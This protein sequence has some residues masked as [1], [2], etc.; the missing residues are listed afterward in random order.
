MPDSP[1]L[2]PEALKA[3]QNLAASAGIAP[4]D[5]KPSQPIPASAAAFDQPPEP[6]ADRLAPEELQVLREMIV[7]HHRQKTNE[8]VLP[9]KP[10][11]KADL[12][13]FGDS[14]LAR[15][16]YSEQMILIPKK[17]E[18]VLRCKT[19]REIDAIERQI[20]KD[21]KAN[22]ILNERVY[23]MTL[24]NYRLM[25]QWVALNGV[26]LESPVALL[27]SPDFD[28]RK[29]ME[30]HMIN[31]LPEP[32]MFM[33]NGALGQF[34]ARVAQGTREALTANFSRPAGDF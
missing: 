13:R 8:F 2:N 33:L 11:D 15:K 5:P 1:P 34:E 3:M 17:F 9:E 14:I 30:S 4:K 24:G 32:M 20:D 18:I 31:N 29:F 23:A 27:D 19:R 26:N 25:I 6:P 12:D 10:M 16:P 21:F 28:L 22:L 7:R